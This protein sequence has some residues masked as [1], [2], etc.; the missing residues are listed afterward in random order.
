[1]PNIRHIDAASGN[2]RCHKD[3]KHAPLK[4]I[5]RTSS[6]GQAAIAMKDGHPMSCAT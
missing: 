6:L 5:Q 2:I 3:T 4:P 1:M